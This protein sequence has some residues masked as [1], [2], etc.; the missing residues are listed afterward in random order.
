[1]YLITMFYLFISNNLE[2]QH[3]THI[4]GRSGSNR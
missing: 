1:M 3:Y 2:D 4:K